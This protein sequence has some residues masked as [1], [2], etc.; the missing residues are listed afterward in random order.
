MQPRPQV[1]VT[2]QPP[3]RRPRRR[4][5]LGMR[6]GTW[7]FGCV[8]LMMSMACLCGATV[9]LYVAAPPPKTNI[10]V[11]GLDARPGDAL[12][13]ARTD[14]V[15]IMSVDPENRRV[16]LFSI[17]RDVYIDTPN[18][19]KIPINIIARN[20]ELDNPGT[21]MIELMTS[22]E[23]EF[24]I[25]IH[26]Y[27]RMD[28]DAVVDVVDAV[29]G[30]EIDVPKRIVDYSYPT[31]DYGTITIEFDPG[32]QHMDGETALIY[33]RTRHSDDDYN[34]AGRQQQVMQA[35]V[36]KMMSPGGLVRIPAV[37]SALSSHTE[38]DMSLGHYLQVAPG[39]GL[40]GR[41]NS[42]E[43][44]VLTREYLIVI[45]PSQVEPDPF[46]A[47]LNEWLDTHLR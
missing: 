20:A 16:S 34:R 2:P 19:G 35:V 5:F 38:S 14:T 31:E 23:N 10:L 44:L 39:I 43:Q 28:F 26:H 25:N 7:V 9:V 3:V 42:V 22:I 36:K 24:A 8:A 41:G 15:M 33:S 40:Y 4:K 45:G 13:I 11:V 21:G 27:V 18:Y 30:V 12:E 46:D 17:P 37:L 6:C 47:Q 29:G 1:Y 32:V